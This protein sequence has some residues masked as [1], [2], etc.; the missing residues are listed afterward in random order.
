MRLDD[1]ATPTKKS[2]AA[3]WIGAGVVLT[4][5]LLFVWRVGVYY[6][7]IVNGDVDIPASTFAQS[8]SIDASIATPIPDGDIDMDALV[9]ADDPHLGVPPDEAFLTIVEF[10]DFG[11]PYSREASYVVRALAQHTDFVH[12]V[13]RDF[14]IV[15][16]H[17]NADW[18]A[19]A[20]ECA[21]EQG[22]FFDYHDKL[23]QNQ[24]DLS[25]DKLKQYAQELG[26]NTSDFN[27]CLDSRRYKAE[28][29]EDRFA[30]IEVGVRGTPTFFLNG[31]RIQGAIPQATFTTLVER[32]RGMWELEQGS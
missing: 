17:P 22:R 6:V 8:L 27:T 24:F 13:Y 7:G 20:G 21:Q 14:P 5:F 25:P 2:H 29:E 31:I 1:T 9:T 30:G 32:F 11:C 16:I 26:L 18:A 19:E 15:E 12:Y 23:Y 4:I 10:A 3:V 28:V